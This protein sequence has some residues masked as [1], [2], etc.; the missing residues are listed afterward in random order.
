MTRL[1][2][3]EDNFSGLYSRGIRYDIIAD[4]VV[5]YHDVPSSAV[6][7][8]CRELAEKPWLYNNIEAKEIK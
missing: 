3:D 5:M 8:L 6:D 2:Y 1:D 4:G 7:R